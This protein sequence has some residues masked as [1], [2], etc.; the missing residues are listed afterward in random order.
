MELWEITAKNLEEGLENL[1]EVA[2]ERMRRATTQLERNA[3][4]ATARAEAVRFIADAV[5]HLL[6]KSEGLE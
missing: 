2:S 3:I 4:E 1:G 6:R 5:I